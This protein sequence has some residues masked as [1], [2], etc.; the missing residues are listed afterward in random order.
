ME[1]QAL[2]AIILLEQGFE[3]YTMAIARK[4]TG[5]AIF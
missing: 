5:F 3:I 2:A 4:S 1:S